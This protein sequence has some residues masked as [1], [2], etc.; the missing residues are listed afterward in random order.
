MHPTPASRGAATSRGANVYA[1]FLGA[2]TALYA[3]PFA[4]LVSTEE[5]V[6]SDARTA[7]HL[8]SAV[9]Y[10]CGYLLGGAIGSAC[11][12]WRELG[13][14]RA[15]EP[16]DAGRPASIRDRVLAISLAFAW[17]S[18]SATLLYYASGGYKKIL[19]LGSN[20]DAWEF[21]IIGYDDVNRM[22]TSVFELGRRVLMPY[23][24]ISLCALSAAGHFRGGTGRMRLFFATAVMAA[25]VNLDRGPVFMYAVLFF[26]IYVTVSRQ[27]ALRKAT[28]GAL[29]IAFVALGGSL[30]TQLQYN[31]L[32]FDLETI[33][34]G[35]SA[36]LLDRIVLDPARMGELLSFQEPSLWDR[37]L[38]LAY[39]RLSVLWGGDY[40]GTEDA[41]SLYVSPTG[42][43]GDVWR[44]FGVTGEV[45]VGC[46]HGLLFVAITRAL[47][48]CDPVVILPVHFLLIVLILYTFY[49]GIFSQGPIVLLALIATMIALCT[50]RSRRRAAS[51][52]VHT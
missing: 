45:V 32:D 2:F 3:L 42:L 21:R 11:A 26:Y 38:Y 37:P 16:A 7:E 47:R 49:S 44:N 1:W 12:H 18:V 23:A 9:F 33:L 39:S 6:L 15:L 28:V 25:I 10:P 19:M 36:V 40:V 46:L 43:V 52:V 13:R 51:G 41:M 50:P 5:F 20:V 17:F 27:S 22:L 30:L 35:G 14:V 29:L 48:R 34:V 8:L 24:L 4:W 31:I